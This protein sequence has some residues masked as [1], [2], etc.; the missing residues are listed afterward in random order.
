MARYIDAEELLNKRP[1]TVSGAKPSE[2]AEGFF[3][4]VDEAKETINNAP[5]AD[6]AEVVRCKDCKH[7]RRYGR[8][9]LVYEGKN[10][11]CGWCYLRAKTDE[12]HRMLPF[13][14]CSYGER[15]DT[16]SE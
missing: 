4:C 9:S 13:D 6:V 12:E 5:S 2:Y 16:E 3:D 15:K 7:Y 8:T 1:F 11:K 14:F 10:I